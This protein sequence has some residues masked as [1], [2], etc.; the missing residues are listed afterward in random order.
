MSTMIIL[1][2]KDRS[3]NLKQ[4]NTSTQSSRYYYSECR[5]IIKVV[6]KIRSLEKKVL[7]DFKT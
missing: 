5:I 6:T 7:F 3:L 4:I 1:R 2:L